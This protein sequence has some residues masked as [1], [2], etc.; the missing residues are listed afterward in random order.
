MSSILGAVFLESHRR[1]IFEQRLQL[2]RT[3]DQHMAVLYD[4]TR[5]V[6]ATLELQQVLWL[7]CERVLDALALDRLWLLWREAPDRDVRA[8]GAVRLGERIAVADLAGEAS[9]WEALFDGGANASPV[10]LAVTAEQRPRS[11]A[12]TS[13]VRCCGFR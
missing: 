2:A 13:R 5:T 3:H 10:V 1:A 7:V 8:L 4:V 9:R 6:A 11:A 12:T